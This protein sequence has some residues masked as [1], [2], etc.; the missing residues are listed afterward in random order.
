MSVLKAR[1][2]QKRHPARYLRHPKGDAGSVVD[3]RG[4]R[5]AYT[6][7]VLMKRACVI[8]FPRREIPHLMRDDDG[9]RAFPRLEITED[10]CR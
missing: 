1:P 9:K 5:K 10:K 6:A 4:R 2:S 3:E 7:L 8:T